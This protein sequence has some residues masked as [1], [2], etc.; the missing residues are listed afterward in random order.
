MSCNWRR[1]GL[2]PRGSVWA[3]MHVS[4]TNIQLESY[5]YDTTTDAANTKW[6]R[7]ITTNQH[8]TTEDHQAVRRC[9]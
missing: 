6:V 5:M 9:V 8:N 7:N 4:Y 2:D 3:Q 1:V